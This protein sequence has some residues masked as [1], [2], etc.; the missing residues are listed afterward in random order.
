MPHKR[1]KWPSFG[2]RSLVFLKRLKNGVICIC[3][4]GGHGRRQLYPLLLLAVAPR[5]LHV[6]SRSFPP[7]PISVN[8]ADHAVFQLPPSSKFRVRSSLHVEIDLVQ[9]I[10]IQFRRRRSRFRVAMMVL[11]LSQ[12]LAG[13]LDGPFVTHVHPLGSRW[14]PLQKTRPPDPPD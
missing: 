6:R 3:D 14:V 2:H 4:D 13:F 12:K 5:F 1:H 10:F 9:A 11:C 8:V 7:F